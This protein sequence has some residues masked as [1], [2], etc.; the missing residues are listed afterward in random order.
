MTTQGR[1]IDAQTREQ[2]LRM[3]RELSQRK[4]AMF[5]HVSASTVYRV[6]QES[7]REPEFPELP[8]NLN[9]AF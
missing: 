7:R 9:T 6:V 4:A 2:I 1:R 5:L 8:L 3:A